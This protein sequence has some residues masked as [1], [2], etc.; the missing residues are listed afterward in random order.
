MLDPDGGGVTMR[1]TQMK[2]P[3]W[4]VVVALLAVG[5]AVARAQ[6]VN[7]IKAIVHDAVV[8]Y[9]EV[10]MTAAAAAQLL[11]RQY[12]N[13]PEGFR[14][15]L[16]EVL[17][18]NLEQLLQRQLILRDFEQAGHS[19]PESIVDEL[20]QERIRE[21]FGGDRV[22]LAK[23]LQ[24]DGLTLEKFRQQILEQ[25][26]VEVM[27]SRNV[28]QQ[29]ILSPHKMER[30]YLENTDKFKVGDQVR[31]R[32]IVITKPAGDTAGTRQLMEEIASKVKDGASF[33]EM[34]SVYSQG[35]QRSQG[36]D[37]GW[38]ERSTLRA[39]LAEV[40][41]TLKSGELSPIVELPDAFY[42]MQA[43]EVR[44]AHVRP[45]NEVRDDIERTLAIEERARAEKRYI[46][47]LRAKTF[48]RYF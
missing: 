11:Q 9:D 46:E 3:R 16:N 33:A 41:F 15:K 7:G 23:T 30:Y 4:I 43:E 17:D 19:L 1:R 48:V 18:N 2:M 36:G 32:M 47:K 29:V 20:V 10:N 12:R 44:P 35:S 45:L 24:A 22:K 37:W 6:L 13:D 26:I 39:E 34:A 14:A 28:S 31:L 5:G 27:R 40:A 38:I 42:L 8:T 21:R 25:F